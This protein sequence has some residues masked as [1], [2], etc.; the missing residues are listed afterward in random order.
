MPSKSHFRWGILGPGSIA[1]QFA[2]GLSASLEAELR[3]VAG[4]S[5]ARSEAF[6]AEFKIPKTY[7][8]ADELLADPEIDAVYIATP[9]P[10][11]LPLVLSACAAKKAV[12]CEKPL[13]P[14]A[15]GTLQAVAAA[16]QHGVFL[17]EALWTRFLPAIVQAL[18]W[19][20]DG[21]IGEPRLLE[22][23]FG[24]RMGWEPESRLLAP[25]LAGGSLL[26][27]GIYPLALAAWVFG[28]EPTALKAVGHVGLT[29][30]DEQAALVLSYPRGELAV[31]NSAVRTNTRHVATIYGTEGSVTLREPWWKATEVTLSANGTEETLKFEF[32]ANGYEYEADEVQRSV[33]AG[34]LESALVPHATSIALARMLDSARE[35]LGV[36]YPFEA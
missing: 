8:S 25:E 3:A 20:S 21:R 1:K 22:A 6:A 10:F 36:K 23:S 14:N 31:V 27:V 34:K 5:L 35:Q 11:H 28:T 32:R 17:M 24:F 2:R 19:I 15:Q 13:T 30:V 9:H 26:D 29:G 16:K 12:L 7:A 33:R 18:A 4:R